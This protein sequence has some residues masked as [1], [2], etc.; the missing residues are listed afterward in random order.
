M[1]MPAVMGLGSAYG[2]AQGSQQPA[3]PPQPTMPQQGPAP[4]M[5]SAANPPRIPTGG[6]VPQGQNPQG[7]RGELNY[8]APNPAW[9]GYPSYAAT[10][11]QMAVYDTPQGGSY[12]LARGGVAQLPSGMI[13]G[14]GGGMDDKVK[15]TIDGRRDVY[16]SDGEYVVDA[17]TISA[18]GDGSS[19][20]GA[21]RMKGIVE[22]I[23]QKK[24]GSKKQPAKMANLGGLASL[25]AV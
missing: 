15:G 3:S 19:E 8:F 11:G 16:L 23:R 13:R 6:T 18:L 14:P 25:G 17:Q 2:L 12:E 20:A 5:T 1:L 9:G 7:Y 22:D 4:T 10:G 24:F 21:K